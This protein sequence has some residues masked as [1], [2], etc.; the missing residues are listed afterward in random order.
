MNSYKIEYWYLHFHGNNDMGYDYDIAE[1]EA[2]DEETALDIAKMQ[3][4]RGAKHFKIL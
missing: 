2:E 4:P 1:V 3:A